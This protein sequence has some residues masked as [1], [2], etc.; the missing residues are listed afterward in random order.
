[1]SV[2]LLQDD[3]KTFL[4]QQNLGLLADVVVTDKKDDHPGVDLIKLYFP[5]SLMKRPILL[6]RGYH[7]GEHLNQVKCS[8]GCQSG[9]RNANSVKQYKCKL[10]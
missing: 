10:L 9:V 1:M 6:Q 2:R 7:K 3:C 4:N 5:S 8:S